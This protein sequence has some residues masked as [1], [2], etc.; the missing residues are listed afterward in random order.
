MTEKLKPCPFCSGKA[1]LECHDEDYGNDWIVLCANLDGDC[2]IQPHTRFYE[3]KEEA[4]AAW[5]S[6]PY[7]GEEAKS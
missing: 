3:T 1:I 6:R 4:I 7:E 2:E 5:N